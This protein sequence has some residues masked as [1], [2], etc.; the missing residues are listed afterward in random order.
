MNASFE[1]R[2]NMDEFLQ[3]FSGRM[4]YVWDD[5]HW[6]QAYIPYIFKVHSDELSWHIAT[7]SIM[8]NTRKGLVHLLTTMTYMN[9]FD[10]N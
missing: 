4:F 2:L 1:E 7:D 8:L 10:S 6:L 5:N 3:R 9:K